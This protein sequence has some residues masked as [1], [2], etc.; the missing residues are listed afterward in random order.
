MAKKL[1][2]HGNLLSGELDSAKVKQ[3]VDDYLLEKPPKA[4]IPIDGENTVMSVCATVSNKLS[5]VLI[6]DGQLVFVKDKHRIALDLD[7]KRTFYNQ[8]EELDTDEARVSM[9]T[10]VSGLFYFVIETAVL[11]TYRDKWIP[12][13]TTP[14]DVVFFGTEFPELGAARTLYVDSDRKEISVWDDNTGTYTVVADKTEELTADDVDVLF[15][16][17]E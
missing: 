5:D 2:V 9:E 16:K 14:K 17:F 1:Q 12:V 4:Q 11:W 6:T 13:T 8:I 10:P 15:G 3:I 7:G